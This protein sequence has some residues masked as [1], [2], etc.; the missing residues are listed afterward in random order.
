M[1]GPHQ[2]F[3][4]AHRI[5]PAKR[6]SADGQGVGA[7][8]DRDR[9]TGEQ[10][11][12]PARLRPAGEGFT[13]VE[14]LIALAL[15]SLVLLMLFSALTL[16][17]RS[18]DAVH[19]TGE[20]S[21]DLRIARSLIQRALR[22]LR[23]PE[24]LRVEGTPL[25]AL[26]GDAEGLEWIAELSTH[27]GLPGLYLL[28]LVVE[29]QDQRAQLVL[30]RWLLHPDIL[31]GGDDWPAWEPLAQGG[32]PRLRGDPSEQ[33]DVN[34]GAFGRTL[35]I[36]ELETFRIDYYGRLPGGTGR[37]WSD[38]WLEQRGVPDL[39]RI[40]LSTPSRSWAPLSIRLLND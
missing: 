35:L 34:A 21:A 23:Q 8:S 31:D 12:P 22:Q 2:A 28:R 5:G 6:E 40:E 16:A 9:R 36:P 4:C 33:E 20:A 38:A 25:R 32:A 27:L 30:Y 10:W 3:G 24:D 17:S 37:D 1:N 26:S 13:L 14:L 29:Q 15:I 18:W 7:S 19:D 39:V 11:T